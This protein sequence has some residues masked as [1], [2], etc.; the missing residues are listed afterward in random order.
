[1][2]IT[3]LAAS[4][5]AAAAATP[6]V[7]APATLAATPAIKFSGWQADYQGPSVPDEP[8]TAAKL[9]G[10]Y[11][12]ITNTTTTTRV[13]GGYQVSDQGNKHIF[14]I[15]AG[16]KLGP[17]QSVVLRSGQG[18]NTATTLFWGQ[19]VKGGKSASRNNFVWNND[20]DVATLKSNT[21]TIINTCTYTKTKTGFK[22]C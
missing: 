14:T 6:F 5:L 3:P 12:T 19:F 11:I 7:L 18:T 13:I 4:A 1:M 10:E 17:K 15:P 22:A 16:F 9:N 2:R 8:L 20:K 21:G